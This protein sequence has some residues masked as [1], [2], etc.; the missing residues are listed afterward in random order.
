VYR[1]VHRPYNKGVSK[2]EYSIMNQGKLFEQI[3]NPANRHNPYPLYTKLRETPISQ[4]EDGTYVV[5]TYRE[6]EALLYDPRISSDERKSTRGAGELAARQASQE[7][8][9]IQAFLFL[10]PPDHNHL[11][12]V[13]MHQFSPE[14]VEGMRDRVIQIVDELLDAQ[15]NRSQLDIVDDFAHPLPV[16]VIC[17]MLGIPIEDRARL[18]V[19][20]PALVRRLEPAQRVGETQVEQ[21]AQAA[22][23]MRDYLRGLIA[24]RH[25]RPH[26]DLI[27]A[28][29][30]TSHDDAEQMNE[31]ELLSSVGLLLGAGFETTVNLITNSMLTLLRH[32]DVLARLRRDHDMVI[33]T[34]EEVQ[35][36]DPPVQFRTRTTLIDINIA[37]VTIPKG[38]TV[39]LLF[40]SGIRDAARFPDPDR[41]DPDRTDNEHF[42]FGR[43]I[44]YC[45]GA[46]LARMETHIALNALVRRLVNPRLV[47]DPP[48]YRELASLRGPQHLAVTFDDLVD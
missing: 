32:P 28:L 24:I 47:T 8:G 13:V 16:R 46:P 48:P 31:Q 5:S 2:E 12:R 35:R 14:R 23:Q 21:A 43:G 33:R 37:G 15:R 22:M 4:Q 36:Y 1:Q 42:G 26:D 44:H 7:A 29:V 20:I 25:D 27:S 39:V 19:W 40:G 38:A 45:V 18:E 30:A 34:L 10:D 17:E 11:R 41:F 9:S 6:I 3:L